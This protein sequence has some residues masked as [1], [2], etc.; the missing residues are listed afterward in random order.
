MELRFAASYLKNELDIRNTRPRQLNRACPLLREHHLF[1]YHQ[2]GMEIILVDDHALVREGLVRLLEAEPD[3]HVAGSFSEGHEAIEFAAR[4]EPDIAILDVAMPGLNGIEVARRIHDVA[5]AT[6]IV[7][8][9]M[10]RN[11]EYVHDALM[12]G[13][14]G[15][16]LKESAGRTLVEAVRAVH[17]GLR[18]LGEGLDLAALERLSNG[19]AKSPLESLSVREQEVLRHTVNGLTSAETAS[20]LGISPKSV[21]TYR[22]RLMSKLGIEDVPALVKFA[23]R[24]GITTLD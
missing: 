20:Q 6:Q 14:L 11:A 3:M 5:P 1:G 23:I 13:A 15:Y 7:V 8:L 2:A 17:V 22:S 10:Y 12:S 9:S 21:E 18:F 19:A 24:H 4:E 16:V